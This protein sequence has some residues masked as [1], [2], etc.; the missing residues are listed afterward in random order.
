[1]S[2]SCNILVMWRED[3]GATHVCTMQARRTQVNDC[4]C[5]C[6]TEGVIA[7]KKAQRTDTYNFSVC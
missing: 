4:L 7:S 6:D 5:N 3:D 2:Q 1:M